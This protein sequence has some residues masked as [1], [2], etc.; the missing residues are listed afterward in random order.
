MTHDEVLNTNSI[1]S[2]EM[3]VRMAIG[4]TNVIAEN[5]AYFAEHG[6]DIGVLES[7]TSNKKANKRSDTTILVKNLP[8]DMVPDEL[9]DMFSKYDICCIDGSCV[10]RICRFGTITSFLVPPSKSLALID[11]SAPVDARKAFKSLAYRKYHHTPLYLEFAPI[12]TIKAPT[13]AGTTE[14]KKKF[15]QLSSQVAESDDFSTLYVKNLSFSTTEESLKRHIVTSCGVNPDAIRTISLPK[16]HKDNKVLSMGYG[17]IE[18]NSQ[19]YA[20]VALQKING[21]VLDGHALEAKPSD[22]RITVP[23][24]GGS[25]ASGGSAKLI[26]R[27]LAFQATKHDLMTLFSSFGSVKRVRIPKKVGNNHRGFAFVDF[28]TAQEAAIAMK[29]LTNTHLYGRHLVIEYAKDE[30]NDMDNVRKRAEKDMASI[31]QAT[32]KR[33]MNTSI[34]EKTVDMTD[35][36]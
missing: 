11:F 21:A 13:N 32:K 24:Q 28:N 9:Q 29:S 27:N 6:V 20:G 30:E 25:I 15:G 4:E 22:K 8:F 12:N 7:A 5:K 18:F 14:E 17:F 19:H 16:K 35:A 2:G 1:S 33:K 10:I 31:F 34:G 3:A 23:R 36:I 26:V